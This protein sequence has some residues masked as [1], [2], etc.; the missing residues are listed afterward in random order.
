MP[1]PNFATTEVNMDKPV[2]KPVIHHPPQIEQRGL[3]NASKP[4][5]PNIKSDAKQERDQ[6]NPA[7]CF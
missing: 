3:E 1:A 6:L 4:A 7:M 5:K 2:D